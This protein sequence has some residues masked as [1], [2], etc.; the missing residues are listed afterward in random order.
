[1]VIT[2]ILNNN[3]VIAKEEGKPEVVVFG[4]GVGFK[5]KRGDPVDE[6]KIQTVYVNNVEGLALTKHQIPVGILQTVNDIFSLAR[7]RGLEGLSD[8]IFFSL[9]DHLNASVQRKCRGI[10]LNNPFLYELEMYFPDEWE[11]AMAS[12]EIIRRNLDMEFGRDE[13][14]YIALHLLA[15]NKLV[16]S[17]GLKNTMRIVDDIMAIA[18]PNLEI[19]DEKILHS[20][21]YNRLLTHVKLFAYRFL[22]DEQLEDGAEIQLDQLLGHQF[23]TELKCIDLIRDYLEDRYHKR[24]S[25]QEVLYLAIHFKTCRLARNPVTGE[26]APETRAGI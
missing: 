3:A 23:D 9:S 7:E 26:D 14:G 2:G 24:I 5:K 13:L 19:N 8:A 25:N 17:V 16:E 20:F 12:R 4:T 18:I 6:Q 1:M 10:E 21:R 11:V 22:R 15:E